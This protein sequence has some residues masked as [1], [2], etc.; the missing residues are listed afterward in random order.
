MRKHKNVFSNTLSIL[1]Q[2]LCVSKAIPS[3]AHHFYVGRLASPSISLQKI[4][5]ITS[6]Y[7]RADE[8][9]P[10]ER[11]VV[12]TVL[13]GSSCKIAACLLKSHRFSIAPDVVYWLS[14]EINWGTVGFLYTILCFSCRVFLERVGYR[15]ASQSPVGKWGLGGRNRR[16]GVFVARLKPKLASIFH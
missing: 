3:S 8:L 14:N 12:T 16:Y 4:W 13:V 1:T 9:K 7:W 6:A 10:A 5:E 11:K 15:H 2:L